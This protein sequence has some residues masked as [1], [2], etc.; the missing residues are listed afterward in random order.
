MPALYAN[1]SVSNSMPQRKSH[2][3]D[4]VSIYCKQV[5][6]TSFMSLHVLAFVSVTVLELVC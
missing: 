5:V 4:L 2:I 3:L 1:N 6:V